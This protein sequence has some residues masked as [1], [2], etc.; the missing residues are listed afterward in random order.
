MRKK[1]FTQFV[2]LT[3]YCWALQGNHEA[4]E[5]LTSCQMIANIFLPQIITF[6][7]SF[8]LQ[9]IVSMSHMYFFLPYQQYSVSLC[10]FFFVFIQMVLLEKDNINTWSTVSFTLSHAFP[11]LCHMSWIT[12]WPYWWQS[13]RV[14]YDKTVLGGQDCLP[15]LECDPPSSQRNVPLITFQQHTLAKLHLIVCLLSPGFISILNFERW[16]YCLNGMW[17]LLCVLK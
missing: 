14:G 12:E 9:Q 11:F 6:C 10:G 3:F 2:L 17:T 16:Y 15:T 1:V 13:P 4:V 7:H 5:C 8:K